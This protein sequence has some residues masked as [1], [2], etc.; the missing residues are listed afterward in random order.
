MNYKLKLR[1][2]W[3]RHGSLLELVFDNYWLASLHCGRYSGGVPIYSRIWIICTSAYFWMSSW[4]RC[5][6]ISLGSN[7]IVWWT[8]LG[9]YGPCHIF[10]LFLRPE[11]QLYKC[12]LHSVYVNTHWYCL[13]VSATLSNTALRYRTTLNIESGQI[14]SWVINEVRWPWWCDW[15]SLTCL[16]F[17]MTATGINKGGQPFVVVWRHFHVAGQN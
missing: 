16:H 17:P 6:A 4:K 2:Q 8:S 11:I 3:W 15:N 9:V 7:V 1:Q 13:R 10:V 14:C 12:Y 5:L